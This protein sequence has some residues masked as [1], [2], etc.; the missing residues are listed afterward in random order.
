VWVEVSGSVQAEGTPLPW[1]LAG[2]S[3]TVGGARA[4]IL[5]VSA[6]YGFQ[7]INFQV[8]Q[9]AVISSSTEVTLTQHGKRGSV[10]A[11][12]LSSASP[13]SPGEFFLLPG[14]SFGA[15][16]HASDY[17]L[18]SPENPA[19]AG[20]AVI[21]Y[22]TGVGESS[23]KVPTGEASPSFPL[24]FV[25]Q[26]EPGASQVRR[27]L[28]RTSAGDAVTQFFGLAPGL[29]GIYQ[30]NFVLPSNTPAGDA[31]IGLRMHWCND[32]CIFGGYGDQDSATVLMRV[33]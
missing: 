1:T 5:S 27:Y 12:S 11:P 6:G 9:E 23:P 26:S 19:R 15:F 7:Q 33:Q 10:L 3:V 8:P 18:V 31:R 24:A 16:Q 21:G 14:S 25:P 20:E 28:I 17:S 22:L 4:P 29:V 32:A 30:V 2:V 13:P